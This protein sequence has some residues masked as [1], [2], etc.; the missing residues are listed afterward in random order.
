MNDDPSNNE[1]Q[2][3]LNENL[4]NR[5]SV[6]EKLLTDTEKRAKSFEQDWSK[7]FDQNKSL[8]EENHSLQHS[9]ENLRIQKGGFGF[10][11]LLAS[12]MGGFFTALLLCFVYVKLIKPKPDHVVVFE[13]FRREN[14]FD[15]EYQLSQGNFDAVEIQLQKCENQPEFK[16]VSPEIHFTRKILGAT[17]RFCKPDQ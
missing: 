13:K 11:T 10:K 17:R 7:L 2:E 4:Q 1:N 14:Q 9:Y 16:A 5:V 3:Q 12:G 8:R 6:L 15:F